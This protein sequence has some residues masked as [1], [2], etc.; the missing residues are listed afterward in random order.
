MIQ[1][2]IDARVKVQDIV[3]SQLPNF[4]L[5]EAPKTVDFLKQYYISQEY[6]GGV[7]D[8]AENLDQY[9]DLDNLTPEVVTDTTSLSVGIGTQEEDVVTVSSTKGF[10][11]KYG[12][13]KIDNEILTYTGLTTNTFT[14]LTRGFSGITSYHADLN[15]EELV[16]STSNA[17]VHTA[18]ASIQNLS[19]LFL[20]EFYN[21]FKLTF[22][23]GFEQLNF[24]KNLKV[25]NFLKEIKS[26]YETKGTDAAL[27]TL[28]RV[29]YGVDPKI[30]NLEELLIKPS[31]AQYLRREVVIAEVLR[32]NPIGLVGQT[33]KKIEKLNDP[34]TSASV[35]EVE[36]FFRNNK[37]YFKFS[38]FIG[39]DGTSLVEGNF[40]ITANTKTVESVSVGSSTISV[41]S[42]I[43]FNP[44]GNII[45]GINTI[46]YTDKT[47]N[48][49]L[50]CT[51]IT[52]SILPTSNIYSDEIYFG[53]EDGDEEKIVEFRI[54][55]IL[56]D[57]RQLSESVNVSEG[58]IIKIKNIG[59]NIK[60]PDTKTTKEVFANSWIYNTTASYDVESINGSIIN[61]KS[62]LDRS[63]L[64]KGDF[65]EFV[66]IGD[67]SIVV[68]PTA[69]SNTP[70]VQGEIIKGSKSV[71]LGNFAGINTAF[72]Y[73]LR[74][75]LNKASSN[76][77]PIDGDISSDISNIYFDKESGYAASNSLPS[78][79][80]SNIPNTKFFEN[81]NTKINKLTLS[82][83]ENQDATTKLYSQIKV[84]ETDLVKILRTGDAIFYQSSGTELDGLNTGLYYIEIFDDSAQLI[85]L[86][87]SRSFIGSGTAVEFGEP[88]A[89]D[90]HSFTLFSQR[91]NLIKPRKLLKKFPLTPNLRN[92]AVDETISGT[93]G[94]LINGVEIF[95]YKSDDKVFFG[96]LSKVNIISSG[97]DYDV[98]NPPQIG[99]STGSG[100]GAVI[101]PVIKGS[102]VD[103]FIDQQELDIAKVVS[104]GITGGNGSGAVIAPVIGKRSRELKFSASGIN[105]STGIGVSATDNT[106]TFADPHNLKVGESVIYNSQ[107]GTGIGTNSLTLVS[108][109]TYFASLPNTK[110]VKLH[111]TELDAR[112]GIN[113]IELSERN[114]TQKLIVGSPQDTILDLKIL[115]SGSNY[116]N[117]TLSISTAG[118]STFFNSI[119]FENHGF[120]DGDNIVYSTTGTVIDGLDTNLQYKILKIN[121]NKF[122]LANAGLGGTDSTNFEQS[123]FVSFTTAGIGTQTFKYPDIKASIEYIPVGDAG[124]KTTA[125]ISGELEITP[126]VRG[127]IDDLLLINKGTGYGSQT[128]NFE[129]KPNIKIKNG[130]NAEVK[131]TIDASTTGISSVSVAAAGTDYFSTPTL[132]VIDTTGLGNG[133]RL[134]AVLGKTSTGELNGKISDVVIIRSGI[135][136]SADSTAVRVI[137]AGKNGVLS[138]NVRS[139]SVNNN[140]KYGKR[141]SCLEEHLGSLQNVVC[142]YSTSPFQDD[143]SDVSSII[144]WAYDGNPIYGP[145]GFSDPEKKTDDIKLL[146]SSY[147]LNSSAVENR[148]ETS[149]FPDGF[150]IEDFQYTGDGD[151]DEHNGRY[152]INNDYPKGVYAYH[153]TINNAG[154][155]TF[156]YFIGNKF[157]SKV[158][159]DNFII[160]QSFDFDNSELRRNT[161]PYK[162]SDP[163]AGT[164]SLTET[165]EVTTQLSE[166][167]TVEGGSV[168]SLQII[169]GGTNHKVG[170]VLDFDS[171]DTEGGGIISRV[172]SVKGVGINSVTSDVLTYNNSVITKL[173]NKTLK[174][175]P[176]DN[177]NLNNKDQVIISGLTSSLTAVNSTYTVGVSSLTAVSISTISAGTAT[178]EIYISKLPENVSVGNSI[179]IGTETLKILNIYAGDKI[180]TV[181]RSLPAIAHTASTPLYIIPDSFTINKSIPDFNSKVNDKFFFNPT[182]TVG[183]GTVAGITTSVTYGFGDE[184]RTNNIPQQ[185]IYLENHPFRTNQKISVNLP[186]ATSTNISISTSPTGATM[187]LPSEVFAVRKNSN[188][189]GIKTGIGTDH[190]GN[191]FEEVFFRGTVGG[192]G[193]INS[194]L[195]FF[196]SNF[197]QEKI[198][199]SNVKTTVSL[200]SNNHNL[201]DGDNITLTVKPNISAGIG[202]LTE[203][204]IKR[205]TTTNKILIDPVEGL[206]TGIKLFNDTTGSNE[207]TLKNH[208][209]TTGDKIIYYSTHYAVGLG[210]SSYYVSV[211]DDNTFK[212]CQTYQN[213]ISN[214]PKEIDIT[215]AAGITTV[216]R[217]SKVNPSLK[218]IKNNDLVFNLSDVS[219]SNHKFKVYYDNKFEN[220][221]VSTSSTTGFN[222]P[223]GI[224]TEGTTNSK[225]TIGYGV[226][227]PE[228]L[229]Y[230]LEKVGIA[231][232]ADVDVKNYSEIEYI[233]SVFDGKYTVSNVGVSSFTIDVN[234]VPERTFY[235][236][237][238]CDFLE[239]STT[240]GLATGS[241]NSVDLVSGG[242]NYKKLPSFVGVGT[243]TTQDAIII[244][245][246]TTIGNIK[247]TRIIN[248]GFEY[249]S[250]KTLQPEALIPKFIELTGADVISSVEIIDGGSG[251]TKSPDLLAIDTDNGQSV[252]GLLSANLSGSSIESV[253]VISSP[254]GLSKGEVKLVSTNNTNGISIQKI[255][256]T[257]GVSTYVVSITKP[258]GGYPVNPFKSGDSVFVEGIV[259]VGTAGS[260]FNSSDYG[261]N[262]LPVTNYDTSGVFDKITV[263]VSQYTTN[264]GLAQTIQSS[265]G[266][267][268]NADVYP[269]FK[270]NLERSL[271]TVGEKLLVNN[272]E[273]DLTVVENFQDSMIKVI[274]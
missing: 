196:E 182:K 217:L 36:S 84:N 7:V 237:T 40:E 152:E 250:D 160:N 39:Y 78:A 144:G 215:A 183:F 174:I 219:L 61:V 132:E 14:G 86:Y 59:Q 118:I 13:L 101:Q 117:R 18:G 2:G 211:I 70:Y 47:V 191:Q 120:S 73:K 15:Q 29:L 105:T 56:S 110:T 103:A 24:D 22:A 20:K 80:N 35:S 38:L 92:G 76:F 27:E 63:S 104:I 167:Q 231:L 140:E 8:I 207:I 259:R 260:G 251:F 229:Y 176:P 269:T 114:G 96:P 205:D 186:T 128:L 4:I 270:L 12:L 189:I 67:P 111:L 32:G 171:T 156:P 265:F 256:A 23:P 165:H 199:L 44:S 179:G 201:K 58:D 190:N 168:E 26:F 5:E 51:G 54:T 266:V 129:K 81:V 274:G 138:V 10:P 125:T 19:T 50:G 187:T 11:N 55:G 178:T 122:G 31:V 127:E 147:T 85:K 90:V 218:S 1:T 214:P 148:P 254:S 82:S 246:S 16:F 71:T 159:S 235:T 198:N 68:L 264:V 236:S 227:L 206:T 43:G 3:S 252:D 161:F 245:R 150:F 158:E 57:F 162:V 134:K 115:N 213:A 225:F 126:V 202:T 130:N 243:T 143:G 48:Q 204:N 74:K 102:L 169:N 267:I 87:S 240:S 72:D 135:G 155:S 41:D 184:S 223:V 238:Q 226:S 83:V 185:G 200:A 209:L 37:R 121:E 95:N 192:D 34:Q 212:L 108:N 6:Q 154:I 137:P 100:S 52:S 230:N 216:H 77:V 175:T 109:E 163:N 46:S 262:L 119:T 172:K 247:K 45:S 66:K 177:H 75:K 93:T 248:E 188:V 69:T 64:K 234:N 263:D 181:Q 208:N 164:D 273:R 228:K 136:Y 49:F 193:N 65:V 258:A 123:N 180:L 79:A 30:I 233:D 166:I 9:L 151:L 257:A 224:V 242:F 244:P 170:E 107:N 124:I 272:F 146:R 153:A 261:F 197:V 194:D 112:S 33:I 94:I 222:T 220:E 25:G 210:N 113:P 89:G 99:I 28:F 60:N 157:R 241:I 203:V 141:Q 173:D 268:T 88:V 221:F 249:S 195:Y 139:L 255:D 91:S 106:I 253:D 271:F 53:F 98:I 21:K 142:G 42:T 131:I 149:I 232:T 239:Y 116:S 133:A 97:T 62:E 145:Y 17:G